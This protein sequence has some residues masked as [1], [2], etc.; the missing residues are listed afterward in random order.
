M[1]T[2]VQSEAYVETSDAVG[3]E[4]LLDGVQGA[5]CFRKLDAL[6]LRNSELELSANLEWQAG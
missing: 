2:K 1:L 4:D 5:R 3:L 6:A